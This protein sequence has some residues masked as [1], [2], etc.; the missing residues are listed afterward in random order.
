MPIHLWLPFGI[1]GFHVRQRGSE[2]GNC[3]AR[4]M[5]EWLAAEDSAV[6]EKARL[7]TGMSFPP[8]P[9]PPP[10]LLHL[11]SLLSSFFLPSTSPPPSLSSLQIGS[12]PS[13]SCSCSS[14]LPFLLYFSSPSAPPPLSSYAPA[15][16]LNICGCSTKEGRGSCEEDGRLRST[17]GG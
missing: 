17:R 11:S 5:Q 7:E 13:L 10:L 16:E 6:R 2:C 8:P 12:S 4:R 14:L 3:S 9:P 1:R 15:A